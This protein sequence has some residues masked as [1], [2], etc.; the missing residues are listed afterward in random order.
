MEGRNVVV[1]DVP[2]AFMQ[3]EINELVHVR[4]SGAMLTLLFEIDHDMYKDYVVVEKGER[5]M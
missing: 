2:G 3:A 5:V 1:L 4:F